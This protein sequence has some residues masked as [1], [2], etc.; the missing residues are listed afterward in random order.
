MHP[1]CCRG[2]VAA[3]LVPLEELRLLLVVL[4]GSGCG[5]V[6]WWGVVCSCVSSWYGHVVDALAP[7]ADE[8]RGRLRYASGSCQPSVDPGVSEWG[9]PARVMPCH[10]G[11]NG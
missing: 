9:N 8:G 11:L 5:C 1:A 2:A 10:S 7:E 4:V 3:G 6:W